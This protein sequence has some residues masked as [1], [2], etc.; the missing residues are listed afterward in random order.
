[1]HWQVGCNLF[2]VIQR[3]SALLP[4]ILMIISPAPAVA[5]AGGFILVNSAGA[6][7][8]GVAIRRTGSRAWQPLSVAIRAGTASAVEFADPDCAFDFRAT[9]GG[10]GTAVWPGVNLC[11]VKSVTLNRNAAGAVWVDYD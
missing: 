1:L 6:D 9:L 8:S 3:S 11:E 4:A 10:G 5:G 2:G 7:L